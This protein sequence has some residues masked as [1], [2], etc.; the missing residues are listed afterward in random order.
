[1]IRPSII[2]SFAAGLGAG[3]VFIAL[4]ATFMSSGAEQH[5]PECQTPAIHYA[6][7]VR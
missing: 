3:S 2:W 1:M 5:L 7:V 6:A 4:A